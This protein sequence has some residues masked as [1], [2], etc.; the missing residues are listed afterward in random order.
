MFADPAALKQ[1]QEIEE[2]IAMLT[3]LQKMQKQFRQLQ[4]KQLKTL[5]DSQKQ[6][7]TEFTSELHK[8]FYAARRLN[9]Q[10]RPSPASRSGSGLR[11]YNSFI[12]V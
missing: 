9:E 5:K 8:Q 3:N 10:R 7:Q 2:E 12:S 11:K 4:K 1:L 6:Q